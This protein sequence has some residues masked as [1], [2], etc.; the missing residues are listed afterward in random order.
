MENSGKLG[1]FQSFSLYFPELSAVFSIF[2]EFLIEYFTK[3]YLKFWVFQS[4][5]MSCKVYIQWACLNFPLFSFI[6]QSFLNFP[7]FSPEFFIVHLNVH[8]HIWRL[9]WITL[10]TVGHILKQNMGNSHYVFHLEISHLCIG[11]Y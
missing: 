8:T 2:L 3:S 4:L 11:K 6:L 5:L 9:K 1:I 7:K 10:Y